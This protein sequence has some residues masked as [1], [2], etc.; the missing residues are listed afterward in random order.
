M[1][2]KKLRQFI[3]IFWRFFV[4]Y[5]PERQQIPLQNGKGKNL[6]NFFKSFSKRKQQLNFK[7]AHFL[8]DALISKKKNWIDIFQ[9]S[10][11]HLTNSKSI[12]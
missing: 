2:K 11:W 4:L 12:K 9:Q 8:L 5:V 1:Q 7:V 6:Y 10:L 3:R